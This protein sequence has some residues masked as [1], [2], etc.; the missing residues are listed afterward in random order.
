[1]FGFD[2]KLTAMKKRPK[3]NSDRD[4][5]THGR[6]DFD[7]L[8]NALIRLGQRVDARNI[9][10]LR[11]ADQSDQDEWTGA[12]VV[13]T[14]DFAWKPSSW[15]HEHD[16]VVR[17]H[18]AVQLTWLFLEI[19]DAFSLWI[20]RGNKYGFYGALAQAALDHLAAHQPEAGNPRPLLCAVL[21][22]AFL[23]LQGI[24]DQ[25]G[26]PDN[27]PIVLHLQDAEGRQRRID[28]RT[29]EASW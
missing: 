11:H 12:D 16:L 29:G 10:A 20:Y 8:Q 1:M 28:L 23:S 14:S 25:G 19:R 7:Q 24:R 21:T 27:A 2:R 6:P 4:R 5:D 17:T 18:H 22:R 9:S 26:I 13:I 3:R 15:V